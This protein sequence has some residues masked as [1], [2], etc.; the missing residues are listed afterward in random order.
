MAVC[1]VGIGR[2][3]ISPDRAGWPAGY[4]AIGRRVGRLHPDEPRLT[5]TAVLLIDRGDRRALFVHADLHCGSLALRRHLLR[6][7]PWLKPHE[8]ILSGTHTHLGPG[9]FYGNPL[10]DAMT[11]PAPWPLP[12]R[13][14]WL[15]DRLLAAVERARATLEPGGI[16]WLRPVVQGFTSNRA[17]SAFDRNPSALREAFAQGPALRIQGASDRPDR[18]VDPRLTLLAVGSPG[19][20]PRALLGWFACHGTSLGPGWPRWSAEWAGYA[21]QAF[22]SSGGILLGLA[23]GSTGDVSPMPLDPQ[24][25]PRTKDP[26]RPA[27]PGEGLAQ[28]IGGAVAAVARGVLADID[29]RAFDLAGDYIEWRVSQELGTARYGLATLGGAV[30][31]RNDGARSPWR[32]FHQG[33]DAPGYSAE[34]AYPKAHPQ[35][36]KVDASRGIGPGIVPLGGVIGALAPDNLP[37]N[38]LR[39]G[40]HLVLTVP[41]EPTTL[42]GFTLERAALELQG[43]SGCVIA[44]Y[45]GTYAGY[46]TTPHEYGAQRYEAASTLFGRRALPALQAQLLALASKVTADDQSV[47]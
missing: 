26:A 27:T 47:A 41:G 23:G 14:G 2:V 24:G 34:L 9:H 29:L 15:G 20:L 39:V 5:A 46:W 43:V 18:C 7:L 3:D 40:D 6:H 16:A 33:V 30:D 44:G 21:R 13:L 19:H 12:S 1:R 32:R 4:S 38:A 10:F 22:E 45:S 17:L 31:G 25:D 42:A 8:L 36:P 37:L 28:A 35:H 11:T